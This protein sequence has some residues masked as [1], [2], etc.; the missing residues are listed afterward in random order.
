M[1]GAFEKLTS[2]HIADSHIQSLALEASWAAKYAGLSE[3]AAIDLVSRNIEKIMGIDAKEESRDIVVFEGNPL[4]YGA[5]VVL[6][7]DGDD[8]IVMDCWPD[9]E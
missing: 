8:K 5:S 6:S 9:A 4:E 1:R 2:S 7:L 3:R